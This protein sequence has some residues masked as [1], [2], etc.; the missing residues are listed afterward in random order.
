MKK[1]LI[2]LGIFLIISLFVSFNQV[3]ASEGDTETVTDTDISSI[4]E[5]NNV[6][7]EYSDYQD[8]VDQIYADIYDDVHDQI[9]AEIMNQ[10]DSEYYEDIYDSVSAQLTG[11]LDEEEISLY[12]SEFQNEIYSVLDIAENSVFGV[13]N[14][15]T[16]DEA[17]I[18]SGV[19]Y[20]YDSQADLYYLITN[21]HVVEDTETLEIRFEDKSTVEASLLGYD[22]DVDIAVVTFSGAGLE[23]IVVSELGNSDENQV[24]EFVLA[25]GNPK[26]YD[27]YRSATLGIISG[28]DR[29][30]DSDG[31]VL[32]IQHDAAI[33]NGNSGGPLYNLDGEV[34]GI[35]VLKLSADSIE[36]F[37]FAIPIN[38]VKQVIQVIENNG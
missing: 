13:T 17:S 38:T 8:L 35:N 10:I 25:V 15:M 23:N 21:Y 27:F 5:Y 29:E 26:G 30:V 14:Y 34:I 24:S 37:G 2:F 32:Y 1:G 12:F 33:N 11:L 16:T 31:N 7:Y 20:K 19:V 9:Y 36:G 28:L 3:F 18:G 4:A 6:S 22:E